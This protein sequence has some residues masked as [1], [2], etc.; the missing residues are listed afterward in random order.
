[1]V[2]FELYLNRKKTRT[3]GIGDHGVLTTI[4]TWA[5]AP[6]NRKDLDLSVGGL[7]SP[8]REHLRWT[9]RRVRVGDEVRVKIVERATVD[10]PRW[11]KRPDAA[12]ELRAKKE[13]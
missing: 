4:L 3:A 7:V 11:R 5:T 2:A 8:R 6:P 1:M 13:Y 9:E 10:R 12:K